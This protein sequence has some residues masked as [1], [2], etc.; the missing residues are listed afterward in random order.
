MYVFLL[1]LLGHRRR[2]PLSLGLVGRMCCCI[3]ITLHYS[4]AY[5]SMLYHS[6]VSL[7]DYSKLQYYMI[8]NNDNN[9]NNNISAFISW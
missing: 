5:Q 8:I 1:L 6:I 9:N 4:I 7:L 3:T 2:R